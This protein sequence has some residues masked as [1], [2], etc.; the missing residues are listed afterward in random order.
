MTRAFD[1]DRV[2]AG[3]RL[4]AGGARGPTV[5]RLRAPAGGRGMSPATLV[6]L[7][8]LAGNRAAVVAVQR[9]G[10]PRDAKH[11]RTFRRTRVG[12]ARSAH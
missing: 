10:A 9:Q 8:R 5:A 3:A 6:D 12:S 7:Q 1:V 2:N 4:Q 11:P